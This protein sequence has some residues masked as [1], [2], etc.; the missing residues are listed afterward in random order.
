MICLDIE[1]TR[2]HS[3]GTAEPATI[4]W[5]TA[6]RVRVPGTCSRSAHARPEERVHRIARCIQ[7]EIGRA[8][9]SDANNA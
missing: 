1:H 7:L 9:A 3:R 8:A 4:D 2:F 5:P 6:T